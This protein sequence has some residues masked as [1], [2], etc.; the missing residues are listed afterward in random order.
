[1][2]RDLASVDPGVADSGPGHVT[3][4][5]GPNAITRVAQV[6]LPRVG[7]R[8]T[9]DL[10]EHAG[11]VHHLLSPP[12]HMVDE[13]DVRTLHAEL[14]ATL[15]GAGAAEVARAA[16]QATADYLLQRRIPR[17]AQWLLARLP[18]RWAAAV[19]LT[20]L[21]RNAWTFAGSGT[22][23]GRLQ[24]GPAPV[25]LQLRANPLCRGLSSTL[26]VCEFYA[27]TFERLF[28]VLV[29]PQALAREIACEACGD[30]ACVFELTW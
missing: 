1:M 21:R 20:A 24:R 14:R 12:E 16:G 5:I 23:Q 17:P 9:R 22:F 29:H 19:L 25:M 13:A 2:H 26:P 8:A 15:G 28:Q 27:A 18:P 30:P 7:S 11:L 3:G 10:F 6:L 4:R